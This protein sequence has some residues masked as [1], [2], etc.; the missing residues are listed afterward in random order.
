MSLRSSCLLTLVAVTVLGGACQKL[1]QQGR[2][3][4][5]AGNGDVRTVDATQNCPTDCA[6]KN[7]PPADW[8]RYWLT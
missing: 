8:R 6:L 1:D 2:A 4:A 5:A 3:S 7:R